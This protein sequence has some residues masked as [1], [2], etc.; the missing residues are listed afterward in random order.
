MEN[1]GAF[2]LLMIFLHIV[3]D[4]YL[5]GPLAKFKQ[6]KWWVDQ[7]DNYEEFLK[8]RNDHKM[9]LFMH[10]FSWTF[11]IMLPITI[12]FYGTLD[13]KYYLVFEFNW[14]IHVIVDDLKANK[15]KINLCVDQ[16]IHLIQVIIT[17]ALFF[18]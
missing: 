7:F 3:D 6:L 16:S 14:M 5:Q 1:K 10:A 11:M 15:L 18:L 4:Y 8:Y 17:W 13:W 9:A 12:L 2:L